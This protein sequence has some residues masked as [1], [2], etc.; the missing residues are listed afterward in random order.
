MNKLKLFLLFAVMI[1]ITSFSNAA[2]DTDL[3]ISKWDCMMA[4][5]GSVYCGYKDYDVLRSNSENG[6]FVKIG[7][8]DVSN[9]YIVPDD[10][11]YKLKVDCHGTCH[12]S[13]VLY[14]GYDCAAT[15]DL[16]MDAPFPEWS[17]VKHCYSYN[18][19][20]HFDAT[21]WVEGCSSVLYK[22][23]TPVGIVDGA[24]LH[25]DYGYG[26]YRLKVLCLD[27]S[28]YLDQEDFYFKIEEDCY[29]HCDFTVN[30][31][32]S[33]KNHCYDS[34]GNIWLD[35]ETW[36]SGC[37]NLAYKWITPIGN[38]HGAILEGNFGYGTY[39]LKVLCLDNGCHH[40]E[41]K[42]TFQIKSDCRSY[43]H[44]DMDSPLAKEI[45]HCYN[46]D[47]LMWIDAKSWVKGCSK[48]LFKWKTP[49]GD[50]HSS[51]LDG[52]YGY[53]KFEL[54]AKCHDTHCYGETVEMSFT[55]ID[56]CA[57]PF[58]IYCPDDKSIACHADL[59][60]LHQYGDPYYIHHGKKVWMRD[61]IVDKKIDNC[62]R[63]VVK[64]KWKFKDP[65]GHWHQCSQEIYVGENQYGH[66]KIKWPET[67]LELDGC[68]PSLH[69]DDLPYGYQRPEYSES[70]C[71]QL[72]ESYKDQAFYY[73][74]TCE[75]VVRTWAVIDW[76]EY[77]PNKDPDKGKYIFHQ[78]IKI[79]NDD[80]P[81]V[82]YDNEIEVTVE[83]CETV[84]V[85]LE[86]LEV[87]AESCGDK[88]D[89][90]NDSPFADYGRANASGEY[91]VG[92]TEVIYT[93]RYGCGYQKNYLQK[94]TVA[95]DGV[96]RAYCQGA[97]V[98][99][100]HGKDNDDDGVNDDGEAFIWAKD[101]DLG[102][103]DL[104]G[105]EVYHS[106]SPDSIVMSRT[107]TCA[108]IGINEIEIYI[109]DDR[110]QS[111]SC[112]VQVDIQ[113]NGANITDC[114]PEVEDEEA[115]DDANDDSQD[116]DTDDA[117]EESEDDSEE[118]ESDEAESDDTTDEDKGEDSDS[119]DDGDSE[120]DDS[121]EEE[122]SDNEDS[123]SDNDDADVDDEDATYEEEDEVTEEFATANI[124]GSI[125]SH[126]G[127]A[128]ESIDVELYM[129]ET[130]A[131]DE[132]SIEI[133]EIVVDS[134]YGR[135]GALIHI[136]GYDTIY[137]DGS[138]VDEMVMQQIAVTDDTGIYSM[139]DLAMSEEYMVVPSEQT[140][141]ASQI[142][143]ADADRLYAHLSGADP[144]TDTYVLLAADVD[145]SGAV[146]FADLD[147]LLAFIN[148]DHDELSE[149]SMIFVDANYEFDNPAD[150][151]AEDF[152]TQREIE[153]LDQDEQVDFIAITYGDITEEDSSSSISV[154]SDRSRNDVLVSPNPFYRET[155]LSVQSDQSQFGNLTLYAVDGTRVFN[156][157]V[158]LAKGSNQISISSDMISNSGIY[159]YRL[160]LGTDSYKGRILKI[161]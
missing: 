28:C 87:S 23:H 95:T 67:T 61:D 32:F 89:V 34:K 157:K 26:D 42:V 136:L 54:V 47:G 77:N 126:F 16:K 14:F 138:N 20:I 6:P 114:E 115:E 45:K 141:N 3:H 86:D 146:D 123:D 139:E 48:K 137:H 103:S 92:T 29:N 53:G 134:F 128:I 81:I 7:T 159:I 39:M 62:K 96:L 27:A 35:A 109:S 43:C 2:C 15:C 56:D 30:A 155:T 83:D 88:F 57:K 84:Y 150:P 33:S 156:S 147:H 73:N 158:R 99:P 110:G 44:L 131:S 119:D 55:L 116:Q 70:S 74:S 64:R 5:S 140:S 72:G 160:D 13:N 78:T 21:D 105:G 22:W 100:L 18:N 9:F 161:E 46:S 65:N 151:W 143:I 8:H 31:P 90:T 106:F 12:E 51:V 52:N 108:E 85:Q 91:P 66:P 49:I 112:T 98:L 132:P 38:V 19:K 25:G 76:C 68:S 152:A 120:E 59:N 149:M 117:E 94:I 11:Y 145:R 125:I 17:K 58:H 142:N 69:P 124:S 148:G 24:V 130:I 133:V 121:D 111:T 40:D 135:S 153:N 101:F 113:N 102:S 1:S 107:F 104:C 36:A 80:S 97:I 10:G 71:S 154:T 75:K 129:M 144:I 79:N 63:G 93:V 50:V 41:V 122:H 4:L 118:D 127:D 60:D 82:N 37:S